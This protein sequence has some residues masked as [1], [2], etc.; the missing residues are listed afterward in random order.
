MGAEH[1]IPVEQLTACPHCM[2]AKSM[3]WSEAGDVLQGTS[4]Q[5]YRYDLCGNC[6]IIY[7][8][9]RPAEHDLGRI[10]TQNYAPYRRGGAKD[11]AGRKRGV[12]RLASALVGKGVAMLHLSFNRQLKRRYNAV[13]PNSLFLD[14]GCGAGKF[15]DQMRAKGCRTIGMDFSQHALAAVKA[16]GHRALAVDERSWAQLNDGSVDFVR[17][18]HVLEH[19]YDHHAVLGRL[20]TKMKPGAVLHIAVPN[21]TGL[22]ARLYRRYWHGLDCPRHVILFPADKL[23]AWLGQ[24][25][26]HTIELLHEPVEKDLIRSRALYRQYCRGHKP[27]HLDDLIYRA[28][29]QAAAAVPAII[30]ASLRL[31]DRYHVFA[32]R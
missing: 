29:L 6:G 17:M 32:V 11:S 1:P 12:R 18:N 24:L 28:D 3:V 8:A 15:L 21:P 4:T 14:F 16:A 2:Q 20:Y 31:A 23:R 13:S 22:S 9:T 19:L 26:F 30:A 7:L 5:S 10:Y 25:G 27:V